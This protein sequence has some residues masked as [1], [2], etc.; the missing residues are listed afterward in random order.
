MSQRELYHGIYIFDKGGIKIFV[1][2]FVLIGVISCLHYPTPCYSLLNNNLARTGK[3]LMHPQHQ[4]SGAYFY[5]FKKGNLRKD[6]KS[7]KQ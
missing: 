6:M 2:L 4:L 5:T 7:A 1:F 3:D